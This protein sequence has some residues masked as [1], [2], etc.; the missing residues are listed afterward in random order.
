MSRA[1]AAV[2][3][4]ATPIEVRTVA[5]APPIEVPEPVGVAWA[6]L[7]EVPETVAAA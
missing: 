3:T 1:L 5:W 6:P 7:N 2:S 4:V